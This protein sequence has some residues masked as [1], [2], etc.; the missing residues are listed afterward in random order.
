MG[1]AAGSSF[2]A[3]FSDYLLT[4]YCSYILSRH[5]NVETCTKTYASFLFVCHRLKEFTKATLVK[6]LSWRRLSYRDNY[7]LLNQWE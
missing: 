4:S 7:N 6:D 5:I 1:Q 2:R 3:S